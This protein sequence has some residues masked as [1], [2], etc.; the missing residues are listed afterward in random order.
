MESKKARYRVKFIRNHPFLRFKYTSNIYIHRYN[1]WNL[2]FVCVLVK[3][4]KKGR[5]GGKR[6]GGKKEKERE[7]EG[8]GSREGEGTHEAP[9]TNPPLSSGNSNVTTRTIYCP[10]LF[11]GIIRI[12]ARQE[13]A[14]FALVLAREKETKE[15]GTGKEKGELRGQGCSGLDWKEEGEGE[16]WGGGSRYGTRVAII[17]LATIFQ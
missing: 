9:A 11:A 10:P 14:E 17:L 7:R 12:H 15:Y 16:G 1:F 4:L 2:L 5:K 8:N 6:K 13:F 3:I